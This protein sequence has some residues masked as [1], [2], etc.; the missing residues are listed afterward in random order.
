[1]ALG[2]GRKL[3]VRI[4][5]DDGS[6]DGVR[7]VSVSSWN[8]AAIVCSRP[9]YPAVRGMDEF[10]RP[11]VYVL[12]GA[13]QNPPF[14][15]RIYV[16]EADDLADRMESHYRERDWWTRLIAFS[17]SDEFFNKAHVQYVESRLVQIAR[18]TGRAVL[19]NKNAPQPPRISEA[20]K[21]DGERFLDYILLL[22]PILGVTAFETAQQRPVDGSSK[23][24]SAIPLHLDSRGATAEGRAVP[25][26]FL[27]LKG[28]R[29][30]AGLVPSADPWV[31]QLRTKL[32]EQGVLRIDGDAVELLKDYVFS[33]P[34]SAAAVFVGGNTAGPRQWHDKTGTPLR[35]LEAR[36]VAERGER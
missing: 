21:A 20:D 16:G 13:D 32:E 22:F 25:E 23:D 31:G 24:L 19:D 8:G 18:M 29:G 10:S 36:L 12:V 11:G 3:T 33:S 26:G 1:M 15:P 14:L 4:I 27:V 30:R 2:Q 6:P 5:L 35:D 28:A 34:T 9:Q 7:K 17:S